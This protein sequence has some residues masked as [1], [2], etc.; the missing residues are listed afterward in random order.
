MPDDAIHGSGFGREDTGALELES[1]SQLGTVD[2]MSQHSWFFQ[3]VTDTLLVS[4]S[5]VLSVYLI[6]WVILYICGV[7]KPGSPLIDRGSCSI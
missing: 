1:V 7:F 2:A 6:T 4:T 3:V 5:C